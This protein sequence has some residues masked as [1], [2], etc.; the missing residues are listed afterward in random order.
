MVD[1]GSI[2]C[3]IDALYMVHTCNS[4][5]ITSHDY[6][7]NGNHTTYKSCDQAVSAILSHLASYLVLTPISMHIGSGIFKSLKLLAVLM[8][9]CCQNSGSRL[10]FSKTVSGSNR[11]GTS[12]AKQSGNEIGTKYGQGSLMSD[13]ASGLAGTSAPAEM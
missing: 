9:V 8:L 10:K 4:L 5:T 6:K 1:T 7:C 12:P 13:S 3:T 2:K 11:K